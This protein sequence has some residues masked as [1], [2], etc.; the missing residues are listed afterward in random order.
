MDLPDVLILTSFERAKYFFGRHNDV[1]IVSWEDP[2][3]SMSAE[4]AIVWFLSL[5][6][7]L[8]KLAVNNRGM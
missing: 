8:R 1:I 4:G 6:D 3:V 5:S 7:V 2:D